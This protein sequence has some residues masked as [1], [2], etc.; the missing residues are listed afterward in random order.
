MANHHRLHI[1]AFHVHAAHGLHDAVVGIGRL[2]ARVQRNVDVKRAD[3]GSGAEV[4][5]H[6]PRTEAICTLGWIAPLAV[7][8]TESASNFRPQA[9]RASITGPSR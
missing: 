1:E 2:L 9:C 5:R 4:Y 7:S 8:M 3:F 6:A